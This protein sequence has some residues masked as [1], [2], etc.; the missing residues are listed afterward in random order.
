MRSFAPTSLGLPMSEITLVDVQA[1]VPSLARLALARGRHQRREG[2]PDPRERERAAVLGPARLLRRSRPPAEGRAHVALRGGRQRRDR[3]GRARRVGPARRDARPAHRRAR[4]RRAGRAARRGAHRGALSRAQAGARVRHPHAGDLLAAGRRRGQ[5]GRDA[6][7]GRR[8]RPGHDRLP[9]RAEAGR[10][11][12]PRAARGRRL[13]GRRH[14]PHRRDRAR[15][16]AQP[17]RAGHAAHRLPGGL[18]DRHRG[19]D[20]CSPSSRTRCRRRSTS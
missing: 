15:R 19:R 16:D 12:R 7:A 3:R 2:H 14:R 17:A 4:A 20:A 8:A 18:R 5:R 1:Q 10:G 6:A 11:A 13:L 9:V